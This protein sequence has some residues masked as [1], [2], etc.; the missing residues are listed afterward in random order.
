MRT[1]IGQSILIEKEIDTY[2]QTMSQRTSSPLQERLGFLRTRRL[3]IAPIQEVLAG[4]VA[5]GVPRALR[6]G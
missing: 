2:S 4:D 1:A 5:C 6:S 3:G